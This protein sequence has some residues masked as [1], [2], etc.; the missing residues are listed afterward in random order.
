MI[1]PAALSIHHDKGL[2]LLRWQWRG[3]TLHGQFQQAFSYLLQASEQLRV[4]R[5]LMDTTTLPQIGIDEQAWLS[6]E[7]LPQ[8][9][10]LPISEVAIIL[11]D[12]LYNQ[13][14]IETVL[15]DGQQYE[16]GEIQFF[17]NATEAL[18]WLTNS[19]G[20]GPELELEW[21]QQH[22]APA[23]APAGRLAR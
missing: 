23:T 15:A 6:E 12:S 8:F 16:C 5:W 2:R 14:V 4:R 19:S 7:W 11:P 17:A 1:K 20:R 10:R 18:D 22:S 3:L 9:A 21:Q 13:L